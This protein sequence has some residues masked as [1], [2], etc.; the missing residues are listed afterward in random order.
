MISNYAVWIFW[1]LKAGLWLLGATALA[2]ALAVAFPLHQP[3]ELKSIMAGVRLVDWSDLPGLQRFQAR[4]GTWL[5]YRDYQ[6]APGAAVDRQVAVLVHGSA[7]SSQNIHAVAKALAAAGHRVAALDI[8]GHGASG[9]RGDIGYFGQL[10]DD[11]EDAVRHLREQSPEAEF[12]L[13]GHS[14]GGGFALRTAGRA[15]GELFTRYILLAP[16]LG[17]F[18]P[19]S[20]PPSGEARWV[21]VDFPRI[22]G[23]SLL[24]R[25]GLTCCE[26]LPVLA[27]ALPADSALHATQRY[28]YRLMA[29][30]GTGNAYKENLAA[31][32]RPVTVVCGSK[33][34]LM[35]AGKYEE[36]VKGAGTAVRTVIV[37][38]VDHMG[39]VAAGPALQAIVSAFGRER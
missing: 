38:E 19:T 24:R 12:T 14:A 20:R 23:L 16:F 26:G 22:L 9:T 15:N 35:D 37:P 21:E 36:A 31:L 17:P 2:I 28:S 3:P 18:A 1:A 27:F 10:D 8:R 32:R 5:A 30:F 11:L 39:I 29:N 7:G 34:E 4:D 25:L 13:I 6:P 33:D